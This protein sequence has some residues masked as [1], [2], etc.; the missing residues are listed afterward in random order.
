MNNSNTSPM[1]RTV[2]GITGGIFNVMAFNP[3]DRALY[4]STTSHDTIFN[5]NFWKHP[6]QG[7]SNAVV[8]RTLSYGMYYPLMDIINTKIKHPVLSSICA[9]CIIGIC[10]SPLSAVKLISWNSNKTT[11]FIPFSIEIYKSSGVSPFFKGTVVTMYREI[12]FGGIFGYLSHKHNKNKQ[13]LNDVIF[14]TIATICSSPFNY[15]RVMKYRENHNVFIKNS[16]IIKNLLASVQQEKP[17]SNIFSKTMYIFYNKF[18]VGWGSF[19]VGIGMAISR[20]I[21]ELLM[22]VNL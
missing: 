11:K 20:Q 8:Q 22:N 4:L 9:S 19:R 1:K 6:Y 15:L 10:T 7:V 16:Q 13:F 18:N 5:K 12:A 2:C 14:A 21:Y 17:T 3:F